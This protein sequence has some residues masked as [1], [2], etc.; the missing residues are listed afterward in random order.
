MQNSVS[1]F[2]MLLKDFYTVIHRS[3]PEREL[4]MSG[5]TAEKYYFKIELN[6]SHPV[7]EGHFSGN[8]VV[9]GVCQM[10]MILELVSLIKGCALRL[11]Q[12][13]NVKFI[14]LMVPVKNLIIDANIHLKTA[15]NGDISVSAT[16]Q[17]GEVVF[18]KFKG[19]FIHE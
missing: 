4:S 3:G 7:Y 14:S 6:P 1:F 5:V 19:L 11:K 18:L 9:P 10:Q 12:A 16:I 13:D 15:E 17:E 2:H 8:P